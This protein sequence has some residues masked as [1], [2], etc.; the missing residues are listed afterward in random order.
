MR[1]HLL[2]QLGLLFFVHRIQ[3]LFELLGC[4][5]ARVH[6][7]LVRGALAGRVEVDKIY[8]SHRAFFAPGPV[9]SSSTAETCVA[10]F[11]FTSG[12]VH[13]RIDCVSSPGSVTVSSSA[14]PAER[15]GS[16]YVHRDW[17]VV[18]AAG[19][20]GGVEAVR[21]IEGSIWVALEVSLKVR[22]CSSAE[23]AGL[24]LWTWDVRCIAALLF[25]YVV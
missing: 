11:R 5:W 16:A 10:R 14:S 21:I 17:D 9:S 23:A 3:G 2:N 12:A 1:A 20:V 6:F 25:Q 15:A 18:H 7:D 19:R 8:L 13:V 22:K 24:E 4:H